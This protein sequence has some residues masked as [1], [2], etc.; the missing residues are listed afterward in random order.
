MASN[1]QMLTIGT[2]LS[3]TIVQK[4]GSRSEKISFRNKYLLWDG[5]NFHIAKRTGK[6]SAKLN[7]AV[8]KKH[9]KFHNA[10]ANGCME[11]EIADQVG[12]LTEVGLVESLL[13]A[14]PRSIKSP[15][16]NPYRWDHAF[17]DTGHKGGSTYPK[18]VMPALMEDEAGNLFIKR[19]KGN[20]FRVDTWLR[21]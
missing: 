8:A 6:S 9:K 12:S 11:G 14:V 7:G 1:K 4:T 19:R 16:K 15:G 18:K 17:G 10:K 21:G 5:R 2:L 13:Y 20:I 3:M